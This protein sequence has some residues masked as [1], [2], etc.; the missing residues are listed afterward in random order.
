MVRAFWRDGKISKKMASG[1]IKLIPK[2]LLLMRLGNWRPL[3][4]L[5]TSYKILSKII[6][7]RVKLIIARLV[8]K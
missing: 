2:G 4:M 7:N 1:I 3:M 8:N 5:T 6:A